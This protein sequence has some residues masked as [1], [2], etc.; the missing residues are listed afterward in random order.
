VTDKLDPPGLQKLLEYRDA[1]G[2]SNAQL[3]KDL[4]PIVGN[5]GKEG[6]VDTSTVHRWFNGSVP[7]LAHQLLIE[8][9]V[10]EIDRS[11]WLTSKD[12][13]RLAL[14]PVS[15]RE[16]VET[17]QD[18]PITEDDHE[19]PSSKSTPKIETKSAVGE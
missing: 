8:A 2:L 12:R 6:T 19:P 16:R 18:D 15:A 13:A 4:G 3:A 11:D 1:K 9:L 5:D 17:D 10:P 7:D 14:N